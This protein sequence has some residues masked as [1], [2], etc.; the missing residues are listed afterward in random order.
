MREKQNEQKRASRIHRPL[1]SHSR[2]P[3]SRLQPGIP[4]MGV[5]ISLTNFGAYVDVGSETDGLLH[6]SQLSAD[7]FIQHP[8]EVL[9]PG[10]HIVVTV[11]SVN[12]ERRKL[13]LTLLP[14]DRL[15]EQQDYDNGG[16]D[17]R[18]PLADLQVD[19]EL[20]GQIQRVTQYGAYVEIGCAVPGF[21]HFMDHPGWVDHKQPHEF[22]K[23]GDRVRV[24][25][26]DV[27]DG[28]GQQRVKLT[29]LRPDHL[30]G[31][32]RDIIFEKDA[33]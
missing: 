14:P 7:S 17:D 30:P 11:R 4:I 28:S 27:V 2:L 5:V 3:L 9:T 15:A 18:I 33:V 24:W 23:R 1:N 26:S 20:W 16:T 21:L 10:D 19:D 22:M 25:V 8:R 29:A 12:P 6:I 13:H 31:P 32:R